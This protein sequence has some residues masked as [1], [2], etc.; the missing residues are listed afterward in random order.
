MN[1]VQNTKA[2]VYSKLYCNIK[3]C[4]FC[5]FCLSFVSR[6]SGHVSSTMTIRHQC[7]YPAHLYSILTYHQLYIG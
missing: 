7:H 2:Q 6:Q 1:K 5:D 4:E 3:L